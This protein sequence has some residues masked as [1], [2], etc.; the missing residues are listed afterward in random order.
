M[1]RSAQIVAFNSLEGRPF[2]ANDVDQRPELKVGPWVCTVAGCEALY[3]HKKGTYRSR[4]G[5]EPVPVTA[6]F[7]LRRGERHDESVRHEYIPPIRSTEQVGD[8]SREHIHPVKG[9]P[10]PDVDPNPKTPS[11]NASGRT[12]YPFGDAVAGV[13]GLI[14]F[15]R[16]CEQDPDFARTERLKIAGRYYWWNE[17]WFGPDRDAYRRA[18]EKM[19]AQFDVDGTAYFIEG[20]ARETPTLTNGDWI[21]IRLV[22]DLDSGKAQILLS[23]PKTDENYRQLLAIRWRTPL[24]VYAHH[25]HRFDSTSVTLQLKS[26]DQLVFGAATGR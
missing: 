17:L 12:I 8:M 11:A 9:L 14:A 6:S 5:N 20:Y 24:A 1:V 18:D 3:S 26:L 13:P 4:G 23:V 19:L 10:G 2:N 7:V 25:I 16:L 21:N 15:I 22:S